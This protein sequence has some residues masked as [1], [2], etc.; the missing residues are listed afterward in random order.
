MYFF[1]T[2]FS[3]YKYILPVLLILQVTAGVLVMNDLTAADQTPISEADEQPP[4][5]DIAIK[6]NNNDVV[7]STVWPIQKR[8]MS[9][10]NLNDACTV[11]EF[12]GCM[13]L[14]L[15]IFYIHAY[16]KFIYVTFL[17]TWELKC[18]F[19]INLMNEYYLLFR[20][21]KNVVNRNTVV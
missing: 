12:S 16:Y 10:V 14:Y 3:N 13:Y 4:P 15:T 7:F 9:C 20:V 1:V 2:R 8:Y 19:H 5:Y 18:Q 17:H 11:S 21:T 6:H